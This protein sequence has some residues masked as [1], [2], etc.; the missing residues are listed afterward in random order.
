MSYITSS[1][2]DFS[3]N[4]SSFFSPVPLPPPTSYHIPFSRSSSYF[5]FLFF[6]R[7]LI[8][9]LLL[10]HLF[11]HLIFLLCISSLPTVFPLFVFISSLITLS[12][13]YPYFFSHLHG[14]ISLLFLLIF[15]PHLPF[16]VYPSSSSSPSPHSFLF[17]FSSFCSWY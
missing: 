6:L 4:S 9:F 13:P 1:S 17:F 8:F 7:I 5:S 11:L 14:L 15:I 3:S 12:P 16:S 2:L 10:F